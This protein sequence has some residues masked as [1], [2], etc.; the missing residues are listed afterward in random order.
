MR[1]TTGKDSN[2]NCVRE[3][4]H[5]SL[6]WTNAR[7]HSV[8]NVFP[9]SKNIKIN[10]YR[11]ILCLLF[12]MGVKSWAVTLRRLIEFF[13]LYYTCDCKQRGLRGFENKGV[14]ERDICTLEGGNKRKPEII[15]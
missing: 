10:I 8:Q 9:L 5:G 2:Q 15:A 7:F 14:E 3:E 12:R 6:R 1:Y 11:I 13:L 4:I